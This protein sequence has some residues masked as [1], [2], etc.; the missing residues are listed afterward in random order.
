MFVDP[1]I[2]EAERHEYRLHRAAAGKGRK[3][4]RRLRFVLWPVGAIAV[5]FLI[6]RL[7]V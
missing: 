3:T 7:C 1:V 6:A 4:H 2:L 5:G